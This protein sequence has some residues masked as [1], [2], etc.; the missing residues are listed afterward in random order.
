M[1]GTLHEDRHAVVIVS[2]SVLRM[3]N[4]SSNS[5]RENRNK[6]FMFSTW[7]FFFYDLAENTPSQ[8]HQLVRASVAVFES[9]LEFTVPSLEFQCVLC[10]FL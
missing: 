9:S 6:H 2:R 4:V 1:T 10:F 7:F 8:Q 5:F 3:K